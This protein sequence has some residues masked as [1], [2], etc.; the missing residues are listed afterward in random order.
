MEPGSR[1]SGC[2]L[3]LAYGGY[4]CSRQTSATGHKRAI[5]SDSFLG[6]LPVTLCRRADWPEA[7]VHA[8]ARS[9]AQTLFTALLFH[10]DQEPLGR[11]FGRK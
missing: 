6:V 9:T 4:L 7:R 8:T 3:A 10:I 5:A 1:H 11:A 2:D